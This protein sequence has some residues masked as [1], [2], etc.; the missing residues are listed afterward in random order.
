[1]G[2]LYYD[3]LYPGLKTLA[4]LF[5]LK[6]IND[7]TLNRNL[8][9]VFQSDF[10]L[11]ADFKKL[12]VYGQKL[13]KEMDYD[14]VANC[15]NYRKLLEFGSANGLYMESEYVSCEADLPRTRINLPIARM[16]GV[17]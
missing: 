11:C 9:N 6:D 3:T 1:L 14:A 16:D 5:L 12:Y 17:S 7:P 10:E 13:A 15:R 4:L 8:L 2:C